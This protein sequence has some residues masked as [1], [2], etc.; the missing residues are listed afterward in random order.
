[1]GEVQILRADR[2]REEEDSA[3]SGCV[4]LAA[5]HQLT[6]ASGRTTSSHHIEFWSRG[7]KPPLGSWDDGKHILDRLNAANFQ[8]W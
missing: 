3:I 7:P 6:A 8:R 1:M 2:R 4:D 5:I